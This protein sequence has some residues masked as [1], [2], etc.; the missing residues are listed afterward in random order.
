MTQPYQRTSP[1]A[2][3][4]PAAPTAPAETEPAPAQEPAQ[5][6]APEPI[7]GDASGGG[8][9]T[10][11]VT[12][13]AGTGDDYD[14]EEVWSYRD[15][16]HEAKGRNLSGAGTRE[17]IVARLREDDAN[18]ASASTAQESTAQSTTDEGGTMTSS[19]STGS[20]DATTNDDSGGVTG[21]GDSTQNLGAETTQAET[22]TEQPSGD[23]GDQYPEHGS[24]GLTDTGAGKEQASILQGLSEER[25][26]QQLEALREQSLT[27]GG[28][29]TKQ[30]DSTSA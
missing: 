10:S 20:S 7:V 25:R 22:T 15:L 16:Q 1:P 21:Q 17:E 11:S 24:I 30:S 26:A 12:A 9:T 14:N 29:P 4:A 28:Q 2:Q 27:T 19:E 8:E 3:P 13:D 18:T 6:A 23:P 5:E